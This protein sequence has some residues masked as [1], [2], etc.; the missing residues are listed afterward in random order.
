MSWV[1]C[2]CSEFSLGQICANLCGQITPL[3]CPHSAPGCLPC[4]SQPA[5]EPGLCSLTHCCDWEVQP[6]S[7]L[8]VGTVYGWAIV[9]QQCEEQWAEKAAL[10]GSCAQDVCRRYG[11]TSSSHMLNCSLWI[12]HLPL[13]SVIVRHKLNK[14]NVPHGWMHSECISIP[15][16]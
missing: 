16:W 6:Q 7:N 9:G 15:G 14:T 4:S 12:A 13:L 8:M 2:G 1:R 3:I 11:Q 5:S 10:R